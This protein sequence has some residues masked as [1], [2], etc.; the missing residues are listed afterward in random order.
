M[1]HVVKHSACANTQPEGRIHIRAL[2]KHCLL[3]QGACCDETAGM[4]ESLSETPGA[5][6]HALIL[7]APDSRR[8]HLGYLSRA[9][10]ALTQSSVLLQRRAGTGAAPAQPKRL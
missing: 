1:L 6:G 8:E 3:L 4:A 10:P 2:T 7:R 9:V 5:Y